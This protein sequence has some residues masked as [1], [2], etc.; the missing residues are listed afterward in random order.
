MVECWS[1]KPMVGGSSPSV[2][3]TM[4]NKTLYMFKIFNHF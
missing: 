1:P 3:A 2:P 4:F